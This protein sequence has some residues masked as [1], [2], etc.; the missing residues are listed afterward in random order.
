[1][2]NIGGAAAQAAGQGIRSSPDASGQIAP[3]HQS[4]IGH[5]GELFVV[6]YDHEGLTELLAQVEEELVQFTGVRRIEV[7]AGLIGQDHVRRVEERAR[8]GHALLF[9]TAELCGLVLLALD[10]TQPREKVMRA[11]RAIPAATAGDQAGHHH[12]LQRGEFRQQVVELEHEAD[13]LV[14]EGAQRAASQAHYVRAGNGQCTGV[15]PLQ[16]AEDLQQRGLAGPAG[17]HNAHHFAL[18]HRQVHALQHVQVAE[19]FPYAGGGDHGAA[20]KVKGREFAGEIH[21]PP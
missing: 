21:S 15:R 7:A 6:R 18:G 14:T 10:H 17:A 16:G 2:K 11:C 4:A 13:V 8:H 5:V 3:D 9:T 1:L 20:K 19:T 12:V